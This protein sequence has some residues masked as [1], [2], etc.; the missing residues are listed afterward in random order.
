MSFEAFSLRLDS[1]LQSL[2]HDCAQNLLDSVLGN[3][4]PDYE[5][6]PEQRATRVAAAIA[7][8]ETCRPRDALEAMLAEDIVASHLAGARCY[9]VAL[10]AMSGSKEAGR[11]YSAAMVLQR[12]K[13][14]ALRLLRSSQ[15]L[16]VASPRGGAAAVG[17]VASGAV[18]AAMAP[19][20]AV[21]ASLPRQSEPE[22]APAP[23]ARLTERPELAVVGTVEPAA[24]AVAQSP[25]IARMLSQDPAAKPV[26]PICF[27]V[28]PPW[29]FR[30]DGTRIDDPPTI[31]V[32]NHRLPDGSVPEW[33]GAAVDLMTMEEKAAAW[34]FSKEAQRA[35]AEAAELRGEIVARD[36]GPER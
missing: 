15:E 24:P 6:T 26:Y 28:L 35:S 25:L 20:S 32:E 10:D 18:V 36:S 23:D 17:P 8:L 7:L 22:D 4:G 1:P 29:F 12:G 31:W 27:D 16:E 19:M 3:V 13:Y 21:P 34:W 11:S 14:Q 30:P 9:R 33:D 2:P 5:G